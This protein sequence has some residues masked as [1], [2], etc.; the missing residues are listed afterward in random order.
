MIYLINVRVGVVYSKIG[1][2]KLTKKEFS[3]FVVLIKNISSPNGVGRNEL[4]MSI[5]PERVSSIMNNNINQLLYRLKKKMILISDDIQFESLHGDFYRM[6]AESKVIY[7]FSDE[8]PII[9]KAIKF[10]FFKFKKAH[11]SF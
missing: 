4:L 2:V 5:W 11:I 9:Y 3:L 8:N 7:Y 1:N 10:L 6:N